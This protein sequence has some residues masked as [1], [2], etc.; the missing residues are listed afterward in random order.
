MRKAQT[1]RRKGLGKLELQVRPVIERAI[2]LW[3]GDA[4]KRTRQGDGIFTLFGRRLSL[5]LMVQPK[6]AYELL[7]DPLAS[8]T[9]F[10]P[11]CLICE[12]ASTIGTRL[13]LAGRHNLG[14]VDAF[15]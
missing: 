13:H 2:G 4:I 14:P 7:A 1:R 15:G 8:D 9:G 12:P 3:M 11:R 6:V 10:L 5:H